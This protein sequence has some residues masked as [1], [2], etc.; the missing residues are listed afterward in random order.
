MFL[1]PFGSPIG[2]KHLGG[3]V[4]R[5]P[6]AECTPFREVLFDFKNENILER[7][8]F[9]GP[10]RPIKKDEGVKKPSELLGLDVSG[11]A[12]IPY[13][14][15][16]TGLEHAHHSQGK[17]QKADLVPLPVPP[18]SPITSDL[19]ELHQL[20]DRL[21]ESARRDLLAVAR[22][23]ADVASSRGVAENE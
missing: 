2:R 7:L 19:R 17:S 23:L 14:M 1:L 18:S 9:H 22:G 4:K 20:W 5:T 11:G 6:P 13:P 3:G 12:M 15:T 8:L 16:P 21:D 10:T